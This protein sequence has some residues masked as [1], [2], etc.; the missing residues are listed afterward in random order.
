MKSPDV[1]P[2]VKL[3]GEDGNAFAI[4]GRVKLALRKAGADQEYVDKY[5][6]ECMSDDYDHLLAVTAEYVNVS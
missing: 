2:D 6:K 5:L 3:A 1:K 4:M